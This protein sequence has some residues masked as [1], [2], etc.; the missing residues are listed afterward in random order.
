MSDEPPAPEPESLDTL[1]ARHRKEQ[2]DLV[3]RI[4]QK[5]KQANK[6][7]RKGVNDECDRLERELKERQ[8]HEVAALN[9]DAPQDTQPDTDE[10]SDDSLA[11][12]VLNLQIA[13]ES[14]PESNS[15][16]TSPALK[17]RNRAKDR[18]AKRAAAQHA[19]ILD[20]EHEAANA[21]NPREIER[22]AM[23][24][25]LARHNLSL[26]EIRADGHCLY[27]ALA[28]Q[29]QTRELGLAPKID[30]KV[31]GEENREGYRTVRHAAAA[32][33]ESHAQDFAGFMEDPV[34][35]YVRKVRETGEWG[36]HV[37]LQALAQAYGVR[38]CVLHGDGRVDRIE[39]GGGGGEE[40]EGK[41]EVWLGYYQ[42]SHGLGEHY[43]S[44][45]RL[46]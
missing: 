41:E 12:D 40:E 31:I 13:K 22:I 28:D 35:E 45:R 37:E 11:E 21:P 1:Q 39:G 14:T 24:T 36:G 19:A 43:N 6:K 16:A 32:W 25:Q 42:H 26:H 7:T 29:L 46:G 30:V 3:A 18:L 17:K 15:N 33:I 2:R 10:H 44:L 9:G 4:T 5:K 34:P 27:A 20:A 8:E 23:A 38:I